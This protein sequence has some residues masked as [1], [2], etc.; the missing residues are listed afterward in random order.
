MRVL[1]VGA[2]RVGSKVLLQLKKNP[3]IAVFTVDPREEPQAVSEG[4]I[5]IVDY[6]RELTP[7]D[8]EEVVRLVV[9]DLVLVTTSADDISRTGVP[10]LDMLVEALRGELEATADV[11]II[12]VARSSV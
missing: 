3:S 9:P 8:L 6:R 1:V 7:R 2:G 4:I 12:A 5:D 11:P 10:G